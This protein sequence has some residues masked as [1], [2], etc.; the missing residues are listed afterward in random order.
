MPNSTTTVT[1]AEP[2]YTNSS[3][4]ASITSPRRLS[5][6]DE[7][8]RPMQPRIAHRDHRVVQHPAEH[9]REIEAAAREDPTLVRR[10]PRHCATTL[11]GRRC[12]AAMSAVTTDNG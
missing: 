3:L 6:V 9:D 10:Q 2:M 8:E 7:P 5:R 1:T 11:T 12:G 4:R